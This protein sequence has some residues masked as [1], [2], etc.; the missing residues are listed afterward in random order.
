M[1][2]LGKASAGY[3]VNNNLAIWPNLVI[4]LRL[5]DVAYLYKPLIYNIFL[6]Y[7]N[8]GIIDA[9]AECQNKTT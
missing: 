8:S 6:F 5:F 9:E 3:L 2:Y 1:K 4:L 7:G